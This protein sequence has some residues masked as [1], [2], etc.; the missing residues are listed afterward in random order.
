VWWCCCNVEEQPAE[1]CQQVEFSDGFDGPLE[2]GTPPYTD[3]WIGHYQGGDTLENEAGRLHIDSSNPLGY[4]TG[5]DRCYKTHYIAANTTPPPAS[6][7][8]DWYEMEVICSTIESDL[9]R[10]YW[11]SERWPWIGCGLVG[12]LIQGAPQL[13]I[14]VAGFQD[15][16]TGRIEWHGYDYNY[17]GTHFHWPSLGRDVKDFTRLRMRR[18]IVEE[19]TPGA[20]DWQLAGYWIDDELVHTCR[21]P[22]DVVGVA[23]PQQL[24]LFAKR[25]EWYLDEFEYRSSLAV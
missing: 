5:I 11:P 21:L 18:E 13:S 16:D 12:F 22:C 2:L 1:P 3:G 6:R 14:G 19:S 9:H 23:N 24:T 7:I 4:F 17:T 15:T 8:G 20:L 25:A 10:T